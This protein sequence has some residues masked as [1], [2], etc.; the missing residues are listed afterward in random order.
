MVSIAGRAESK[1]NLLVKPFL[2]YFTLLFITLTL[3]LKSGITNSIPKALFVI[4]LFLAIIFSI[5][6]AILNKDSLKTSAFIALVFSI[7]FFYI[8]V[9]NVVIS[10]SLSYRLMPFIIICKDLNGHKVLI[11]DIGQVLAIFLV[12]IAIRKYLRRS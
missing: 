8:D 12:L 6:H 3:I 9:I 5:V 2:L 4:S 7:I 10:R 11:L 1:L